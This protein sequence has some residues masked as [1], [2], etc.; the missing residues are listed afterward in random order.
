MWS[1]IMGAPAR[2]ELMQRSFEM[3]KFYR[4]F[5]NR[6]S[7]SSGQ[8]ERSLSKEHKEGV[9]GTGLKR[10]REAQISENQGIY[11]PISSRRDGAVTTGG[12][13]T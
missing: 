12:K 2:V 1:Q 3:T 4:L 11:P 7:C 8:V 6:P 9:I 10:C 13:E 5:N